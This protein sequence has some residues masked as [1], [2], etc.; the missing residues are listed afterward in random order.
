[1][2]IPDIQRLRNFDSAIDIIR[3]IRNNT[4]A[5]GAFAKRDELMEQLRLLVEFVE[6]E[7]LLN[8]KQG[9]QGPVGYSPIDLRQLLFDLG[10]STDNPEIRR[11]KFLS[12]LNQ[13]EE[14]LQIRRTMFSGEFRGTQ[15]VG[16]G[17]ATSEQRDDLKPDEA[18]ALWKSTEK[19]YGSW[20]V[21]LLGAL[22]IAAVFLAGAGTFFIGGQTLQLRQNL[23]DTARAQRMSLEEV[24]KLTRSSLDSQSDKLKGDAS[25]QQAQIAE[26]LKKA[27][28]QINKLEEKSDGLLNE[29]IDKI[30]TRMEGSLKSVEEKLST[31]ITGDLRSIADVDVAALREKLRNLKPGVEELEKNVRE[32]NTTIT[33]S[34]SALARIAGLK[35]DIEILESVA[36]RIKAAESSAT[37]AA[38][39]A[40]ASA[41]SASS[42]AKNTFEETERTRK[43]LSDQFDPISKEIGNH[44]RALGKVEEKLNALTQQIVDNGLNS[45]KSTQVINEAKR[46][47]EALQSLWNRLGEIHSRIVLLEGR[48]PEKK[49]VEPG[50]PVPPPPAVE[51]QRTKQEWRRIQRALTGKGYSPGSI[52]GKPGS[53]DSVGSNT[54]KA[55]RAYQTKEGLPANGVLTADQAAALL[56][57]Q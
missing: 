48:V 4:D 55:I 32:G 15:Q 24:G 53:A 31:K 33:N 45:D 20:P 40:A 42:S 16:T 29:A 38:S 52:D 19:L 12:A 47:N 56:R 6:K 49:P 10:Q 27:N 13:I 3:R 23:E 25:R 11:A 51:P 26:T 37:A 28:D 39:A 14:L 36:L 35:S 50:P 2:T 5:D 7:T 22:M 41:A 43:A 1:M 21:R 44:Q 17:P 8:D 34:Q 9:L 57:T 30:A 46:A 18:A 54:R